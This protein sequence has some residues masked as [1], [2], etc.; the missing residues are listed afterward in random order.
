MEQA[1]WANAIATWWGVGAAALFGAG[2]LV[3]GIVGL[4]QAGRARDEARAAN[5]LAAEANRISEDANRIAKGQVERAAELHQ[6]DWE[7]WWERPGVYRV[8]NL[9]PDFAGD[10]RAKVTVGEET[11]VGTAARLEEGESVLL[12]FPG[13]LATWEREEGERV[14]DRAR[15][16]AEGPGIHIAFLGTMH[17]QDHSIRDLITWRTPKGNPQKYEESSTL[18]PLA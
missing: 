10:V 6:I 15:M 13:A 11:V 17:G 12:E 3:V 8:K 5:D 14:A 1:E 9:G 4:V 2:G 18:C 7:C 16:R